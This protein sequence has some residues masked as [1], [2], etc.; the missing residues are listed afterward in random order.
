MLIIFN[1]FIPHV[2]EE[3]WSKVGTGILAEQT[4]CVVNEAYLESMTVVIAIQIKGKTKSTLELAKG[5][6]Q[7]QVYAE[8]LKIDH[9]NQL[10][11]NQNIKKIIYVQDKII[12][13]VI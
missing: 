6:N 5:L 4:W 7:E 8:I 2:C 13:I 11:R 9:I 10:L 3:L 1:P 12:N